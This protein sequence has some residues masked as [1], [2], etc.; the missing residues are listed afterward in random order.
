MCAIA[1]LEIE[2]RPRGL[3]SAS[4]LGLDAATARSVASGRTSGAGEEEL[5]P[6]LAGGEARL[7]EPGPVR[8]PDELV[9]GVETAARGERVGSGGRALRLRRCR[10][11]RD[12][13]ALGVEHS[14]HLAERAHRIGKE[15]ERDDRGHC[16]ELAVAKR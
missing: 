16:G 7:A 9:V 10:V 4:T 2:I 5:R 11:D 15:E 8:E 6:F 1:S 14:A 3:E 12:A 13:A